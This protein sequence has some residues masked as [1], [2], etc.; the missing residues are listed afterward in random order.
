M[1]GQFCAWC[2]RETEQTFGTPRY[3]ALVACDAEH[4]Y[5]FMAEAERYRMARVA[6]RL[7]ADPEGAYAA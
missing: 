3:G 4:A 7:A 6:R 5:A 2:D 1:T